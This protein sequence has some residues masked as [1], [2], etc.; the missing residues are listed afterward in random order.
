MNA[1]MPHAELAT[2]GAFTTD[3]AARLIGMPTRAITS[4]LRG[5]P[6]LIAS[7]YEPIEHRR[8]LSFEGLLEAR[9]VGY[10]LQN[11][12]KTR[13]LRQL[14]Q[15]LRQKSGQRHPLARRDTIST[16]G[17]RVFEKDG[18][19]FVN[20]LNDCYASA[21]LLKGALRGHV[22]YEG[23]RAL[24]LEP[25]PRVLPMVRIDPRRAFGRP[26]VIDGNTAVP[27]AT[28][29]E[30]AQLEGPEG[31]ADWYGVSPEAVR[32]AVEFE[33]RTAA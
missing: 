25:D 16:T 23:A 10:L 20:L 29:A 26:V 12:F 1:L 3:Q 19:K 4:W 13:R 30:A 6:P 31:A 18:D 17:D 5:T 32:Q 24:Y 9:V 33:K 27:T 28:L 7:D 15:H 11:G 14:M 22:E 8:L 21:E 2:A